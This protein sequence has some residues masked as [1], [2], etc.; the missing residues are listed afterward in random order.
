MGTYGISII[1]LHLRIYFR[2]VAVDRKLWLPVKINIYS[3]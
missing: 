3:G 2:M 1:A